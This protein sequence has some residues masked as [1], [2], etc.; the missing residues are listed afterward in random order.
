M[1]FVSG[2]GAVAAVQAAAVGDDEHEARPA[3]CATAELQD[4]VLS[5]A[6]EETTMK[7][8]WGAEFPPAMLSVEA[9]VDGS[10][11][12]QPWDLRQWH[13]RLESCGS[14]EEKKSC[15]G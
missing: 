5:C 4:L 3:W 12:R 13:M 2:C 14:G 1:L 9:G 6:R 8:I 15:R 11:S 7:A 10:A